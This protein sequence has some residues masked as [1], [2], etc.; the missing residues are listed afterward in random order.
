MKLQ[1]ST[2]S[3]FLDPIQP[4]LLASNMEQNNNNTDTVSPAT[5]QPWPYSHHSGLNH[6]DTDKMTPF[7]T[8]VFVAQCN[9]G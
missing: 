5:T 1:Q 2:I 7:Q 9:D 8:Q 4:I 6:A 3:T